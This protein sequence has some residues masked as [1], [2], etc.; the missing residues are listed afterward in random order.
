MKHA[1]NEITNIGVSF[2]KKKKNIQVSI[3]NKELL[4]LVERHPKCME[5]VTKNSIL[6]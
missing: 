2:H 6:N 4:P 5:F 1:L 3:E